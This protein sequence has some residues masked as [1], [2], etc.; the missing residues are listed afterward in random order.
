MARKKMTVILLPDEDNYQVIFPHYSNC[1]TFGATIE[2]AL[3]NAKEAIELLLEAEAETTDL[4][5]PDNAHV[6]HLVVGE[7]EAE[8][9]DKLLERSRKATGV[10][11]ARQQRFRG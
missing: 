7:I 5:F 1:V 2:E 10:S 9:P 4:P 6:G 3:A 8:V 11:S